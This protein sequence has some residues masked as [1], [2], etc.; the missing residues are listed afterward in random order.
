MQ[1]ESIF[2]VK[3]NLFERQS[4]REEGEKK[5]L[6]CA[7]GHNEGRRLLGHSHGLTG[8]QVLGPFCA[9][10]PVHWLGA[11]AQKKQ[12]GLQLGSYG[13]PGVMTAGLTCCVITQTPNQIF[14]G[15]GKGFSNRRNRIQGEGL[16]K[17]KLKDVYF[18]IKN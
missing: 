10:F 11:L 5:N 18:G 8:F 1:F 17:I 6:P 16:L 3:I 13:M 2:F 7:D 12:P 9:A 15:T 4:Y 14:K